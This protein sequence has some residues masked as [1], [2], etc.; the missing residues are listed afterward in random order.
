MGQTS[1]KMCHTQEIAFE[2]NQEEWR[3]VDEWA[4][5]VTVGQNCEVPSNCRLCCRPS[6]SHVEEVLVVHHE[7]LQKV[8]FLLKHDELT[9]CESPSVPECVA[10]VWRSKIQKRLLVQQRSATSQQVKNPQSS[11]VHRGN[12]SDQDSD[13]EF[14]GEQDIR[15]QKPTN[16]RSDW[17]CTPGDI[18]ERLGKGLQMWLLTRGSSREVIQEEVFIHWMATEPSTMTLVS[19]RICTSLP[20]ESIRCMEVAMDNVTQ[21]VDMLPLSDAQDAGVYTYLQ[22]T[23]SSLSPS[24]GGCHLAFCSPNDA[25]EFKSWM[26]GLVPEEEE[27]EGII[28]EDDQTLPSL[29]H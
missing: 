22:L 7:A 18:V 3:P 5:D 25:E 28:P 27:A 29:A 12:S 13:D 10:A 6:D 23:Q 17:Q 11:A 21:A 19:Q 1:K 2:P 24:D 20:V 15:S 26:R 16:F 9:S 14:S 8:N 4:E